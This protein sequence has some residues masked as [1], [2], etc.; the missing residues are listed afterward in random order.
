MIFPSITISTLDLKPKYFHTQWAPGA[1][2]PGGNV[3]EA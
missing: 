1:I 3:A 2:F